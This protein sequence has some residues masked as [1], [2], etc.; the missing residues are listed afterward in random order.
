M[1]L[2]DEKAE[3]F[4][5][6]LCV[7]VPRGAHKL[8]VKWTA[9]FWGWRIW[10]YVYTLIE[11]YRELRAVLDAEEEDAKR[12]NDL[13]LEAAK[14]AEYERLKRLLEE[15]D[16]Q[17]VE[18]AK[19]NKKKKKRLTLQERR[20]LFRERL[21][22]WKKRLWKKKPKKKKQ[23]PEP[24]A[25]MEKLK[26][27]VRAVLNRVREVSAEWDRICFAAMLFLLLLSALGVA[28]QGGRSMAAVAAA[29]GV[30]WLACAI[31]AD[32]E[33]VCGG[34]RQRY[35]VAMLLRALAIALMLISYFFSYVEQGVPTNVVLQGAMI[36]TLALHGVIFMAFI[37]FNRR[38]PL[39]L[40]AL[41]GVLGAAPALTAAAAAALAASCVFKSWPLPLSGVM[42]AAGAMGAFLG[43]QLIYMIHLGGIRLK[44]QNVW[45]CLLEIS[46]FALMLAGA[47]TYT[48][49]I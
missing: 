44:Y 22:A 19:D 20:E 21:A 43:E 11:K 7:V 3:K 48:P 25:E 46:G 30:M 24:D 26:A 42:S 27:R 40:R 9:T 12:L 39:L 6:W 38:Q 34:L 31:Q 23:K 14:Q 17:D 37:A 47:W 49:M 45:V 33:P 32:Y 10:L 1:R 15:S 35:L 16:A 18:N 2:I 5:D 28:G 13:H 8:R 36:V 4:V 29:L 41:A